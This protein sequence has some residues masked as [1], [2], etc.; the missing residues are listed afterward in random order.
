VPVRQWELSLP[1]PLHLLLAG[2]HRLVL[3]RVYRAVPTMNRC[4]LTRP[5]QPTWHCVQ[6][7]SGSRALI[8]AERAVLLSSAES[9]G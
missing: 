5:R 2:L 7:L 8:D 6:A 4:S 3:D 1:I 9:D